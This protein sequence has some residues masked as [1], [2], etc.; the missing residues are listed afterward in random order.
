MIRLGTDRDGVKL[1]AHADP[2]FDFHDSDA[3]R[4]RAT[5]VPA[6][7]PPRRSAALTTQAQPNAATV[8]AIA[9]GLRAAAAAGAG[10]VLLE[11]GLAPPAKPHFCS[12]GDVKALRAHILRED[13]AFLTWAD[14]GDK[15]PTTPGAHAARVFSA[16][17][18]L[19][20]DLA[21][22]TSAD[23]AALP[24]TVAVVDGICMGFGLG[25]A[26]HADVQVLTEN[27]NCAMPENL[28]GL[29][30]DVGF[31]AAVAEAPGSAGVFAALTGRRLTAAD[32]AYLRPGA[33]PAFV[34]RARLADADAA[35][36]ALAPFTAADCRAA[37][38]A[39]VGDPGASELE[40]HAADI[41]Q[42][43]GNLALPPGE[44]HS[45]GFAPARELERS[46]RR[47]R[48]VRT[49]FMR[50]A[51]ER[52]DRQCPF[53]LAA[54]VAHFAWARAGRRD[55]EAFSV[56]AILE[57]EGRLARLLAGR[58]DFSEGVRALLVDKDRDPRWDPA[59]LGEVDEGRLAEFLPR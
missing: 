25:L 34:P 5:S 20:G 18:A 59:S 21:E 32:L 1:P 41:E 52:L 12:G 55:D 22:G 39:F 11:S 45:A 24:A 23:G 47:A 15:A 2:H 16:E 38:G 36:E 29:W 9:A 26:L 43:F 27:A 37:L 30:P 50:D 54:T 44:P 14:D 10:G 4:R 17:Y 56:R 13:A 48:E 19:V 6:R 8:E 35:L 33:G 28:I 58:P 53:S 57:R 40:A 3:S 51:V 7:A 49:E 31:A 42:C 46:L